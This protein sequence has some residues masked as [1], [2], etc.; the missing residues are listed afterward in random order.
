MRTHTVLR[1]AAVAAAVVIPAAA[2]AQNAAIVNNPAKLEFGADAGANFGLGKYS[3]TNIFI[4]GERFRVGFFGLIDNP[5][6][7]VEPA[8][9]LNYGKQKDAASSS[10]YNLELGVLY[11]FRAP[12]YVSGAT[13][14]TV[15]YVRPFIN[16]T[17][18]HTGSVGT[19]AST[20]AH[21]TTL[22]GGLGLKLP[23]R[24]NIALRAEANLGYDLTS[25]AA[26]VGLL[27]GGSFFAFR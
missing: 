11:H 1:A 27:A 26:R 7:E 20:S 16:Y 17:G 21:Q 23:V 12:T 9:G 15:A 4:P 2:H 18:T 10:L 6:I 3:Y 24:P 19:I 13:G 25:K 5:R 14:A 8:V 22:G